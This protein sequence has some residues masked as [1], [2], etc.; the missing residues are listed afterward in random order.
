MNNHLI[1]KLI[2]T[3]YDYQRKNNIRNQCTINC[4][5]LS[6]H[7]T[8]LN[9][10][11]KLVIGFVKCNIAAK[12]GNIITKPIIEIE[13]ENE[14]RPAVNIH[15]WIKLFN[16]EVIDPS[17]DM[18]SLKVKSYYDSVVN[19]MKDEDMKEHFTIFPKNYKIVL[20][21]FI[22]FSKSTKHFYKSGK[23]NK[24]AKYYNN[25]MDYYKKQSRTR[26]KIKYV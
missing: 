5:I 21:Y 18:H 20:S 15:C 13:N 2:D 11:H 12:D 16:G 10:P 17:W 7:L 3:M 25:F 9:I 8:A 14:V 1:C 26:K 23:I 4:V 6:D 24:D 19:L 22:E